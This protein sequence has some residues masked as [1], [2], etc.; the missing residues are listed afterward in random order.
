MKELVQ[1][2]SWMKG[3]ISRDYCCIGVVRILVTPINTIDFSNLTSVH[4]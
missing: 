4:L 3:S 2:I 1:N